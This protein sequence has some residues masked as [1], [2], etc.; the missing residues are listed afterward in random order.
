MN[1][2][3]FIKISRKM[4]ENRFWKEERV[5]SKAEAW[6]DLIQS[7]R[8]EADTEI[9]NNKFIEVQRGE[10]AVSIRFLCKRWGWG[11][12][13]VSNFLKHLEKSG[14]IRRQTR[15]GESV[16][17]L[18]KYSDYNDV[19]YADKT[20]TTTPTRQRR[21][22][23]TTNIKKEKNLRTKEERREEN[24]QIAFFKCSPSDF[25]LDEFKNFLGYWFE[26]GEKDKKLRFEKQRSF[27]WSRRWNTWLKNLK[28][29]EKEKNSAKKEIPKTLEDKYKHLM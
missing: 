17:T 24:K 10:N 2:K 3:G 4:F 12:T 7:T 26:S 14:M 13:K 20:P 8:F 9:I 19:Q 21:D 15:Q 6:I 27:D 1:K 16:L 18:C 23:G 29:W 22:T 25:H 5:Y 11:N 28:K